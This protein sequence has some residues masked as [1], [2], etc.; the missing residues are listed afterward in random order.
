MER[1]Q[2]IIARS[3]GMSR[4]KAEELIREGR[5]LL[6]GKLAVL[7]ESAEP[8]KDRIS[9]DGKL[10]QRPHPFVYFLLNKP[11]GYLCTAADP[12]GRPTV[13]DLVKSPVQ[14]YPVGRL[15]LNSMGLVILTNDGDLTWRVT[16]AGRHCPKIYLAKVAG[17]IEEK[18]LDR[19]RRGIVVEEERLAACEIEKVRAKPGSYTWYRIT[20]YQGRNRQI[21]K[22]FEE[23]HHPVFQLRRVAI[24]PLTDSNLP[25]GYVR[26]LTPQEVKHLKSLQPEMRKRPGNDKNEK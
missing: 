26:P 5:V 18:T 6:N 23:V 1:L 17:T 7:G 24:G 19:L 15:D 12:E 10:L 25:V 2:K 20:L 16:R 9:L 11:R 8:G 3:T 21:R 22:M 13:V 4:R 14:I